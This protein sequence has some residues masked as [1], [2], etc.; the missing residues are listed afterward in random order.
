M[1]LERRLKPIEVYMR[2]TDEICK[3]DNP[4]KLSLI[5]ALISTKGILTPACKA[6][7]TS[8]TTHYRWMN[9]DPVYKEA[10]DSIKEVA[11]DYVE[12]KLFELIDGVKVEQGEDD[13]GEPIVYKER[14]QTAAVIFYLKTLG[15]HRGYIEKQ[16]VQMDA[17]IKQ[18]PFP[19]INLDVEDI[20]V[21]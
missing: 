19:G 1:K 2:E 14:P 20:E 4:K 10:I 15:Q 17:N 16:H 18:A 13:E 9:E 8:H 5:Y 7:N 6:A 3:I 21:E 12:S 11:L